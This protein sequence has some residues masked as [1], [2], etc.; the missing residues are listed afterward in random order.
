MQRGNHEGVI[1][2][3]G[4]QPRC[5]RVLGHELDH[6]LRDLA[7]A[8]TEL[9]PR[10]LDLGLALREQPLDQAAERRPERGVGDAAIRVEARLREV[11][12]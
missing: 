11:A 7:E 10:E 3:A 8:L 1:D 9:L 5:Q 12:A 4:A 2:V 6:D